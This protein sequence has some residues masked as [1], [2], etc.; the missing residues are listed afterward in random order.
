MNLNV[1]QHPKRINIVTIRNATIFAVS[2]MEVQRKKS[3][4]DGVSQFN[5]SFEVDYDSAEFDDVNLDEGERPEY[6][7]EFNHN[8]NNI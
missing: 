6:E 5:D 4:R 8:A 7:H 2:H 3:N 1:F